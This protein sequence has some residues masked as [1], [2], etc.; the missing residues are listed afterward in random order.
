MSCNEGDIILISNYISED[1]LRQDQHSFV[2]VSTLGGEIRGL[3]YD[4]ACN[5]MSSIKGQAHKEEVLKHPENFLVDIGDSYVE[6]GNNKEGYIKANQIYYFAEEKTAY[7]VIGML[8]PEIY[9]E[10][11]DLI[12]SL[13]PEIFKEVID[14][15]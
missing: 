15:L 5:V 7:N 12:Q 6:G 14:N 11:I 2:V 1:G 3:S 8:L 4:F 13:D 10:L 9:Q